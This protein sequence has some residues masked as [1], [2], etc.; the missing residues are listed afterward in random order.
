MN[1]LHTD[2]VSKT[3]SYRE[4]EGGDMELDKGE[5]ERIWERLREEKKWLDYIAWKKFNKNE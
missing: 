3:F 2:C 1:N 4:R 5:V